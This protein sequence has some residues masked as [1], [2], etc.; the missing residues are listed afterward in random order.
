MHA[1]FVRAD[2]SAVRAPDPEVSEATKTSDNP[3][4]T[5]PEGEPGPLAQ[6]GEALARELERIAKRFGV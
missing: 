6:A 1:P 2:G 4:A 3:V 5:E